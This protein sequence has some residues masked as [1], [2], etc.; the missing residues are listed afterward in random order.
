MTV[1]KMSDG[2]GEPNN[3]SHVRVSM[4]KATYAL[5]RRIEEFVVVVA[6]N[7]A[8]GAMY[9]FTTS[10]THESRPSTELG[11]TVLNV[12]KKK[13]VLKEF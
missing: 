3:P 13:I 2:N 6:V 11:L 8:T 12:F 9:R 1:A 7:E 5:Q 10:L 4:N